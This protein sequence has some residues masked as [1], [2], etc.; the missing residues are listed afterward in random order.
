MKKKNKKLRKLQQLATSKLN[1]LRETQGG[2]LKPTHL[3]FK[4]YWDLLVTIDSLLA[5]CLLA[6]QNEQYDP[7]K[8]VP[9]EHI[10]NCLDLAR[11]LLPFEEGEFL[12]EARQFFKEIDS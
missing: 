11:D 10:G 2:N 7:A 9:K 3:N 8:L 6:S 12:D 4:G 1:A 5:V